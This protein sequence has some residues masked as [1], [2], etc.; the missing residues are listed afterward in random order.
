[1]QIKT[2]GKKIF[3]RNKYLPLFWMAAM[4]HY[5]LPG[6][7]EWINILGKVSTFLPSQ[8]ADKHFRPLNP[9]S[10]FLLVKLEALP[11]VGLCTQLASH[12]C[13]W[14]ERARE[15]DK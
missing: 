12:V 7:L 10:S 1:M 9:G 2:C 4:P 6:T 8:T 14:D 15:S 11:R 13:W 5:I 3:T